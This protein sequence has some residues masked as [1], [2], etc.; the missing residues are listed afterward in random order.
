VIHS[1]FWKNKKV[2]ITG[3]TG[4][5]GSWLTLLL[6]KLGSEIHGLSIDDDKLSLS[7]DIDLN[8]FCESHI[9]D[10]RDKEKVK[11]KVCDINP[12]IIIHLAAQSLVLRSYKDPYLTYSTNLIGLVNLFESIRQSKNTKVV[13]NVTSDK[14]YKNF[15]SENGYNENDILGGFDPYSN[16]KAC[17]ELISE[18]YR[19]SFFSKME[20]ASITARAGNVI[21]GGDWSEDRLIPDIM[22]SLID[23]KNLKIRYPGAIRPW[24]H[25]L[26]PLCGYIMLI[27][28]AYKDP[29]KFSEAWNFGPEKDNIRTVEDIISEISKNIEFNNEII[30]DNN[31]ALHETSVL[32]LDISKVKSKL[33]WEPKWG[34]EKTIKKTCDWYKTYITGGNIQ[35]VTEYQINEYLED[36]I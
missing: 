19:E 17:A 20:I 25:V 27:E 32:K 13:L 9:F 5:K 16:S 7:K 26:E 2:L 28:N 36:V 23:K 8:K 3:H 4:F 35:E 18:S 12:E 11:K 21:G 6:N 15:E 33:K 31:E 30:F 14:C 24:Q 10:L 22:K 29:K 1:E 34:F